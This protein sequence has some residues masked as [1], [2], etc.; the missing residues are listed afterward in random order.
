MF[1]A[2]KCTQPQHLHLMDLLDVLAAA[3][4]THLFEWHYAHSSIGWTFSLQYRC[5]S[6]MSLCWFSSSI[7]LN[8]HVVSA[9]WKAKGT[10]KWHK[11]LKSGFINNE[12]NT[13]EVNVYLH[14]SL[15]TIYQVY[16]SLFL[17]VVKE[18]LC[19]GN[20]CPSLF[21]SESAVSL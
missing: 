10:H 18:N 4:Q 8:S 21:F 2:V 11:T 7:R 3:I 5:L 6:F 1:L 20:F 15:W 16:L 12:D 9:L 17:S 14:H 13:V 19:T